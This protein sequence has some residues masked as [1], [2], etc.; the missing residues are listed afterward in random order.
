L[1][2]AFTKPVFGYD[3]EELLLRCQMHPL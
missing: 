2:T 1:I 3:S